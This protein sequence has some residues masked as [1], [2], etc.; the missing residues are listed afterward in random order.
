MWSGLVV[1][2]RLR[3]KGSF[4]SLLSGFPDFCVDSSSG[5]S[6]RRVDS[7][8]IRIADVHYSRSQLDDTPLFRSARR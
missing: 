8:V 5:R 3:C 4:V 2:F 1:Q 7:L 6:R